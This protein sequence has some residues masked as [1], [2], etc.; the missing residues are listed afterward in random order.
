MSTLGFN[1]YPEGCDFGGRKVLNIGC[2]FAKYKSPNVVNV[3]AFD[4]C[5]PD[6]VLDLNE[7]PY[8]FKDNTFDLI[9]ANHIIEHLPNWW[10]C[11]NECARVLKPNGRLEIWVPGGGSDAIFGYRDHVNEIN[12]CSFFGVCG[13]NRSKFNAW[14]SAQELSHSAMLE[15]SYVKSLL[16]KHWW[17]RYAPKS[18]QEWAWKHLRNVT[19]EDGYI[20]R[21]MTKAEIELVDKVLNVNGTRNSIVPVP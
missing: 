4:N 9:L 11:F 8:P 20:F 13:T 14:A 17:L 12:K 5:A 6:I 7:T 3:D 19:I 1:K 2:G 16:E 21:K 10:A 18:F 15:L